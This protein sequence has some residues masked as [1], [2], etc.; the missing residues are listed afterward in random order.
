MLRKRWLMGILNDMKSEAREDQFTCRLQH[1]GCQRGIRGS[2][3]DNRALALISSL[4]WLW[5]LEVSGPNEP[6]PFAAAVNADSPHVYFI[7]RLGCLVSLSSNVINAASQDPAAVRLMNS[8][9]ASHSPPSYSPNSRC[10]IKTGWE[11]SKKTLSVGVCVCFKWLRL[12]PL[13][14]PDHQ[15]LMSFNFKEST[16]DR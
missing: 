3:E 16:K 10:Q 1:R 9:A 5:G 13:W 2:A 15:G 12:Q 7:L 8:S 6:V 4:V 14:F 11:K